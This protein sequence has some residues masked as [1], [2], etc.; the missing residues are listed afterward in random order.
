MFFDAIGISDCNGGTCTE[1]LHV[2]T[3]LINI[4]VENLTI[5]LRIFAACQQ[6]NHQ[7]HIKLMCLPINYYYPKKTSVHFNL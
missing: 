6:M 7:I 5:S 1:L 2:V 4:M 3:K